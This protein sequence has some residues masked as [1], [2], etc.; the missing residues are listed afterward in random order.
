[1]IEGLTICSDEEVKAHEA[2]KARA[3]AQEN[4]LEAKPRIT[5]RDVRAI[6]ADS[7]GDTHALRIVKYFLEVNRGRK[8]SKSGR[9]V[10]FLVLLGP[11]GIGKTVAAAYA[12]R[13]IPGAHLSIA[14]VC[15][16]YSYETDEARRLR[17][18]IE[19]CGLLVLD[20][21]GTF[22]KPDTERYVLQ[23]VVDCRQGAY[24]ATLITANLSAAE[25]RAHLDTRTVERIEHQGSIVELAGKSLRI[26]GV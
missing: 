21:V 4:L 7:L 5:E 17:K 6:V 18:L 13:E 3:T 15:R 2:E 14:D 26:L 16:A 20:D 24:R 9:P 11:T 10:R 19:R 1:M 8:K 22:H 23:Q 25:L 12:F